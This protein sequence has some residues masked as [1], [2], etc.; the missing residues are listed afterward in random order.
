M[1]NNSSA[2]I[3]NVSIPRRYEYPNEANSSD[4]PNNAQRSV[5]GDE[6]V[7]K[8]EASSAFGIR[9]DVSKIAYMAH[10]VLRSAMC[11]V[12]WVEVRTR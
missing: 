9:L 1:Y 3:H 4:A 8:C 12:I 11:P 6:F 2:L 7:F 5:Q 10:S